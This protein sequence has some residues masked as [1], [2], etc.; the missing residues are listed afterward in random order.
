MSVSTIS[1]LNENDS[2]AYFATAGE[3]S[4]G[5][6]FTVGFFKTLSFLIIIWLFQVAKKDQRCV[7]VQ[8]RCHLCPESRFNWTK[9]WLFTSVIQDTNIIVGLTLLTTETNVTTVY[10]DRERNEI[11]FKISLNGLQT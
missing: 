4:P 7:H 8:N 5:L 9:R 11:W 1:F 10:V 3:L 2:L 6:S